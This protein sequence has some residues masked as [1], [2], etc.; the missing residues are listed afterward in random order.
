MDIAPT[1]RAFAVHPAG[2]SVL[3]LAIAHLERGRVLF[4]E[5]RDRIT[6]ADAAALAWQYGIAR[7][8]ATETAGTESE[9]RLAAVLG[10]AGAVL[11][12]P[13]PRLQ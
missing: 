2:G 6:P 8:G 11:G 4:D 13:V 5:I 9:L 1:C 12:H 7:V 3:T 10:A